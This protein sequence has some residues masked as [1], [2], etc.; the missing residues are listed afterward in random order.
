MHAIT[1]LNALN[2]LNLKLFICFI[3]CKVEESTVCSE[4][5]SCKHTDH[6]KELADKKSMHFRI[7]VLLC[8]ALCGELFELEM[9]F[10]LGEG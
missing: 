3:I 5:R 7:T 1:Q 10:L 2:A 8:K 4:P 9:C 6:M